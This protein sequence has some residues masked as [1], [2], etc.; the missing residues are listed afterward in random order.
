MSTKLLILAALLQVLP[1]HSQ[2]LYVWPF[3]AG[4]KLEGRLVDLDI[5]N[6]VLIVRREADGTLCRLLVDDLALQTNAYRRIFADYAD[7]RCKAIEVDYQKSVTDSGTA[8][9][10]RLYDG[11]AASPEHYTAVLDWAQEQKRLLENQRQAA[12]DLI[13]ITR[14]RAAAMQ[15][16]VEAHLS[17]LAARAALQQATNNLF[18][19]TNKAPTYTNH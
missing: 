19:L 14:K 8:L 9:T 10:N 13:A 15:N 4:G 11:S 16:V 3:E 6:V 18:Q 2:S 1:V 7:A 17:V 5:D 12:A